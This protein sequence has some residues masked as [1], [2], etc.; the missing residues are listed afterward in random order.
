MT[1]ALILLFKNY[2][3]YSVMS[4]KDKA[5]NQKKNHNPWYVVY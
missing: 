4:P 5:I 3:N 2:F 1:L